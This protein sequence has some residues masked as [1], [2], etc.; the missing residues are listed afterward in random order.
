M[1]RERKRETLA[2]RG[3]RRHRGEVHGGCLDYHKHSVYSVVGGNDDVIIFWY[4][5]AG[6]RLRRSW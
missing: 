4:I 5:F 1:K 3:N 2:Q 6:A